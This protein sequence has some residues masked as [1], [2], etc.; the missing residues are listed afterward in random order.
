MTD[1]QLGRLER[2][3]LRQ[4][5][6]N[7]ATSFSPWLARTGNL[8]LLAD[9]LGLAELQLEKIEMEIGPYRAD[10]LCRE[11]ARDQFVLIENQLEKTDHD[12]L[13]K[14]LTYAAGVKAETVVWIAARFTDEHR[15]ALDWLN[16]LSDERYA[17]F[18]VEIEAW[19]IGGSPAAPKFNVIAQ[20]N[21]WSRH[22]ARAARQASELSETKK[23]QLDFW[24]G[25]RAWAETHARRI[26][27]T[28]AF[29]QHWMNLAIG[30]T[31]FHLCAVAS[32][33]DSEEESWDNH[34]LRAELW[35]EAKEAKQ[36][37]E[38]LQVDQ[39]AIEAEMGEPLV[40]HDSPRGR[41]CRLFVLRKVDL[42]QRDRWD[43][44]HAW[45]TTKLD[46]LNEVFADRVRRLQLDG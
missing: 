20:P 44:Y 26:R 39:Q 35:I 27:P 29:P 37:F 40:W 21:D 46:K 41:S 12:H 15:A 6:E 7:E 31:G 16:T 38:L 34:V 32:V 2:V 10:I 24:T 11:T 19:R 45:L 18:G 13:G 36:F 22:I 25:F 8:A 1:I 23:L 5:W 33:W 9:A 43:D 3:D 4:V 42:Q 17:F 28:K 30:R 14:L